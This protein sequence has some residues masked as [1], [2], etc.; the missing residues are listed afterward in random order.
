MRSLSFHE[1][2]DIRR[3]LLSI[4]KGVSIQGAR[5]IIKSAPHKRREAATS[6]KIKHYPREPML[7]QNKVAHTVAALLGNTKDGAANYRSTSQGRSK[8]V[9]RGEYIGTSA[10]NAKT[11]TRRLEFQISATKEFRSVRNASL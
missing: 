4:L 1:W 9:T 5:K 8:I 11:S 6:K 7:H 3:P 2:A 10:K